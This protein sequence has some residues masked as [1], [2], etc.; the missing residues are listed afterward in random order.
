MEEAAAQLVKVILSKGT[1]PQTFEI[2][3]STGKTYLVQV[4]EKGKVVES[5]YTTKA[6]IPGSGERCGC[7]R[8]TG[9]AG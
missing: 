3:G 1:T 2:T 9:K 8:G 5:R 7:C 4:F 6:S